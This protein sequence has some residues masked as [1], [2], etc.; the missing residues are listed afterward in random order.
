MIYRTKQK[1]NKFCLPNHRFTSIAM[2]MSRDE[3]ELA[4]ERK[5]ITS[6]GQ[7]V[8][9]ETKYVAGQLA[10]YFTDFHAVMAL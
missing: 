3:H 7:L 8:V 6:S 2:A 10:H 4:H 5:F 1:E 9:H